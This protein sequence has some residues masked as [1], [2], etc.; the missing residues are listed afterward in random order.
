MVLLKPVPE[1][2]DQINDPTP[3]KRVIAKSHKSVRKMNIGPDV[4]KPFFMFN[5]QAN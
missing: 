3:Y 1:D 4:R 2:E 5:L